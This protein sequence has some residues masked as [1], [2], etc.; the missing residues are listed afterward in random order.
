ME[1]REREEEQRREKD[2]IRRL[3]IESVDK[4]P[5]VCLLCSLYFFFLLFFSICFV[6]HFWPFF[7]AFDFE[8]LS[9]RSCCQSVKKRK[10]KGIQTFKNRAKVVHP[11][12]V[13][14]E[15]TFMNLY[16]SHR[17][18]MKY[19]SEYTKGHSSDLALVSLMTELTAI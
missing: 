6:I 5:Q 4:I 7:H 19:Y 13:I 14:A 17:M 9:S 12:A 10:K 2:N 1:E 15:Q 3:K 8:W 18:C 16:F 11:D